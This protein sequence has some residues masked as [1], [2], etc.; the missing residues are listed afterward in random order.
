[1]W[2]EI[3]KAETGTLKPDGNG[4]RIPHPAG[5]KGERVK[6]AVEIQ[7]AGQRKYDYLVM[8]M[9]CDKGIEILRRDRKTMESLRK[10]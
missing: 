2:Q 6:R 5:R 10:L 1:V 8:G 4:A 3:W 9:F 7:A